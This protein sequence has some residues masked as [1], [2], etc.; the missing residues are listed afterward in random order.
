MSRVLRRKNVFTDLRATGKEEALR[1]MVGHLQE[2]G[3][4]QPRLAK[5]ILDSLVA[6]EKM[7]ST[8]IGNGIAIPH[9][10][11]KGGP[12]ETLVAIARS[13]S[14]VDFASIDGEKVKVLFMVISHED[15]AEDHLAILKTISALV[16]DG[17]RHRLLL[18]SKTPEDFVDLFKEPE[19]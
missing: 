8:G 6:R 18:G 10:K 17:Y 2:G 11:I 4:I 15:R 14:G 12:D 3:E 7:G 5:Q 19:G 9:V 16:R 1:E 13:D